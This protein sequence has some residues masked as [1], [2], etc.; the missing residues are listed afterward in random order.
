M[1]GAAAAAD[2]ASQAGERV[3]L[4]IYDLSQGLAKQMSKSFLG[5]EIEAIWHTGVVVYGKEYWFGGGI[6]SGRPS[7]TQYGRPVK[8]LELG[9]TDVPQELFEEFISEIGP[10]YTVQTYSLLRH[11]CNNFSDEV[12][13]FLLG[14]GIPQHILQLPTDVLNTPVGALIVPMLEQF[15]KSLHNN[16]APELTQLPRPSHINFASIQIPPASN[17]AIPGASASAA[18]PAPAASRSSVTATGPSPSVMSRTLAD[19]EPSA[20]GGP[21]S[22]VT[23]SSPE[24]PISHKTA[25]PEASI[26]AGSSKRPRPEDEEA[27]VAQEARAT[28]PVVAAPLGAKKVVQDEIMRE[29]SLLMQGGGLGPSEA[30]AL[31]TRRVMARYGIGGGSHMGVQS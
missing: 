4:H 24:G 21:A 30:A 13:Q 29:F 23:S 25:T 12:V 31:A 17:A 1:G 6:C 7:S 22:T 18:A 9:R 28:A 19:S 10:R 5:K 8:V 26:N 20:N 14:D 2:G 11:N 16:A 3:R 15:E 27:V